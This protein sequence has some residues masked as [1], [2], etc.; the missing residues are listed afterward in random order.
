M[1]RL[2]SSTVT[3]II[4]RF[5]IEGRIGSRKRKG[6]PKVVSEHESILMREIEN[7]D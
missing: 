7:V 6:R 1:F 3:D 5:K 4:K 2:V